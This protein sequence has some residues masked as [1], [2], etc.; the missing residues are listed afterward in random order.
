MLTLWRPHHDLWRAAREF[1]SLFTDPWRSENGKHS[2]FAPAVDV[3]EEEE[4]FVLSADLPGIDEKDVEVT[5]HE[6]VLVL[7]GK[8]EQSAEKQA[9]GGHYRERRYGSFCR[10]FRLGSKV[11]AEKIEASYKNGVLTV[12]IP[13]KEEPKPR[14]IPVST[15]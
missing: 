9:E 4:R 1:D 11:D 7:S 15:S 8:R 12:S 3:T 6:G 2:S 10:Q 13:K 5:V 14:Q